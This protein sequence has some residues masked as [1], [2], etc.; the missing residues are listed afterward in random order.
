MLCL[1]VVVVF[2]VDGSGCVV[3]VFVYCSNGDSEVEV[4]VFVLLCCLVLLLVLLLWL[5]DGNGW[6]ELMEGWFFNDD[7]YF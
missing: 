6:F 2:I 3:N 1:F 4:F 7:G 5:F